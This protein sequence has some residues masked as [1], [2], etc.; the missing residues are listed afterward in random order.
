MSRRWG[1][2]RKKARKKGGGTLMQHP[3]LSTILALIFLAGPSISLRAEPVVEAAKIYQPAAERLTKFIAREVRAKKLP[4]LS[5]ALVDDQRIVWARGFGFADPKAKIA[6]T[7]ETIYRVGSVSKLFTDVAVMQLVERGLLDLDAPITK[8]LPDFKPGNPFDK[9]ITLRQMMA[10]R[11][12]LVREPPVGNYFDPTGPSL[13]KM[14]KSL[15]KTRLVYKPETKTKYSNAAIAAVGFVLEKTRKQPFARYLRRTLLGPL[16]MQHSSFEPEPALTQNLAKAVMWTYPGRE[17]PAPTFELG[18]APAGSMYTNVLDLGRFLSV[19]FAGGKGRHGQI[20]KPETLEQMWTIQF[21]NKNGAKEGKKPKEG[22]GLGFYISDL[23]GRKSIGHGGAI[24]GFATQLQALPKEKLGVVVAAA[25]DVANGVTNHIAKVALRQVLAVKEGKPL[26]AIEETKPLSVAKARRL[27]G[28]YRNGER[29]LDLLERDGHLWTLPDRGGFRLEL[30]ELGDRLIV[31]DRMDY[32]L[33]IEVRDDKLRLGGKTYERVPRTKPKPC[34]EKWRGLLGEYGWDHNTLVILERA[35]KLHALIEWFFLYPLKEVSANEFAFPQ[36]GLYQGEKLIFRRDGRGRATHVEAANVVFKRREITGDNGETFKIKPLHPI[37]ELRRAALKAKPPHETGNFRKPDLVELVRLDDTIKLDIRYATPNNFLSTPLYSSA[38]AFLQ[39]PAAEALARVHQKLAE[40]GYGLL[41]YDAYRPWSVT[42]VFWEAT[43]E[44]Q[45]VFVADPSRGSRHNRGC[46]VD[47]TLYDRR[48]GKP[49]EMVGGYDEMS[50]RS[51]ADYLGGASL[52]RYHRDLLR[53]AMQEEGFTVYEAEWW[54]FDYKD[55]RKYPILN[56]TFEQLA[57]EDAAETPRL[58]NT[59][60]LTGKEALDVKMMDGLHRF[61]EKKIDQSRKQRARHWKRDGSS[62]AA[63]ETSIR[64]NRRRFEKIIGLV[65]PRLPVRMERFGMDDAPALIAETRSHK[66]WQVRWPVLDGV[67]GEGL[68]LEPKKKPVAS[69]IALPDADQTPEQLAGLAAGVK[70]DA[71]FARRLVENGFRVVVPVLVNRSDRWS[72]NAAI[73]WTNQPHREWIYRQAYHMGRHIIGYEVQKILAVVDWLQQRS[74][75]EGKIGVAGYGEGGLLAFYAA[76]VDPRI[77]ACLVSG[78]FDSRQHTW[79]EPIYRNVWGLLREFGD[80]EI[81]TLIAPRGLIVEHSEAP[82]V[83]GPPAVRPGRRGGAAAGALHTPDF[84]S[85]QGEF[86]RIQT[87]LPAGLQRRHLIAGKDGKPIGPGS[88][89]ALQEFAGL[90]GGEL[91]MKL[92]D[93]LP[94][95]RRKHFDLAARQHRQVQELERHVQR[96]VRGA[97]HIR[98]HFFSLN[99]AA[100]PGALDA[101]TRQ[102]PRYR[103]Y[104]WT[105]VL[106][107]FDDPVLPP[108]PRSRQIYDR[109]KWVG[110]EVVLDVYPDVFAWGVLLLPKD[111]KPGEKRPVVVFQHGRNG[112]PKVAIEGNTNYHD[113]AA[114]L[115]ERGFIVF[116]PHNPYRGEDRYRFLSRKANTVK[117]SLFSF[118]LAQHQQI[119]N[120]LEKL[121]QVDAQRIAFY[122]I[123]YGGETA[124]RVP[125]L[126]ERYCLSICSADFN[127]WARK[128]ASTDAKYSFMFTIEWE[129]PYFDMGSTFNYAELAALMAP[130]PFMVERGHEDPVAPDEWVAY[131]YAKVRRLY[132]RLGIGERTAIEFFNGGHEI[133]GHGTFDFLHKHL[134]W[135]KR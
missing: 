7:A 120:W 107:K 125:P 96:L 2:S 10:H 42:K 48:S 102:T 26:P 106:G 109:E 98:E 83:R 47:L 56:K 33:K 36:Y 21:V 37:A 100:G 131:E 70:Q 63:Y 25:R 95:E 74:G 66:V 5:I 24:Y 73:A 86:A 19:L 17:F 35:G 75:P 9:A 62:P 23:E 133:R 88:R 50:D 80:A 87:L 32:G 43:P 135:P 79:K 34:P 126:L 61:I 49:V 44:K 104:L 76:A 31:D 111:I 94:A 108:N 52:Q 30:R 93:A 57:N 1:H 4:V 101:F 67:W 64:S 77:D 105:E 38:K 16:D 117:G 53:R 114:R 20:L 85:V 90:L 14:V 58:P 115:A 89:Q 103:D 110:Y 28:R 45:R 22:F 118:I 134:N 54:H 69:A 92:S 129:M 71:Q 51:Y 60:P 82:A 39:R 99:T 122:G 128:V 127:D 18:M 11:S 113:V 46:A 116:A 78:Y 12:G 112:L 91:S 72:G 15:N 65:D 27:A 6:A 55:W 84:A 121:S 40:S 41:V 123:S 13:A 124:V 130:R 8:Y 68:L 29:W 97:E 132:D 81:A 119:L 3:R 59:G